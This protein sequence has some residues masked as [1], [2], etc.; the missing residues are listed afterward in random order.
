MSVSTFISEI[1]KA[2]SPC[3]RYTC[4][5]RAQCA[6]ELLACRAFSEFVSTGMVYPPTLKKFTLADGVLQPVFGDEALP[7]KKQ[8]ARIEA[9]EPAEKQKRRDSDESV[10]SAID[11]RSDLEVAWMGGR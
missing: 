7:S 5:K 1:R 9:D 4:A 11:S 2:V 6:A 3:D 10:W 8:F